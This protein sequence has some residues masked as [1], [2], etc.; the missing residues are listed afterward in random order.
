[1]TG[2]LI[3]KNSCY[4]QFINRATYFN[5]SAKSL[6]KPQGILWMPKNYIA[7]SPLSKV[8]YIQ[9]VFCASDQNMRSK[10]KLEDAK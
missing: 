8:V 6:F 1:M 5:S 3:R 9:C 10:Y 4:S 7:H 2:V